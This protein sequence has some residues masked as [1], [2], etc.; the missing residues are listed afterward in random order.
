MTDWRSI[1]LIPIGVLGSALLCLWL[2]QNMGERFARDQQRLI[3]LEQRDR[4]ADNLTNQIEQY[5]MVTQWLAKRAGESNESFTGVT[6]SVT[7]LRRALKDQPAS[8]VPKGLSI[9]R[10]ADKKILSTDDSTFQSATNVTID[11]A[12][13]ALNN[14]GNTKPISRII[15]DG[16]DVWYSYPVG[17]DTSHRLLARA[18]LAL[19][20]TDAMRVRF[21]TRSEASESPEDDRIFEVSIDQSAQYAI[22]GAIDSTLPAFEFRYRTDIQAGQTDLWGL[23]TR[24]LAG[25][26]LLALLLGALAWRWQHNRQS[27]RRRRR[28]LNLQERSAALAASIDNVSES[29][30]LGFSIERQDDDLAPVARAVSALSERTVNAMRNTEQSAR[31]V[32]L[33]VSQLRKSAGKLTEL[34]TKHQS[35]LNVALDRLTQSVNALDHIEQASERTKPTLIAVSDQSFASVQA[36]KETVD[37][38]NAAREQVRQ[39]EKRV[40]GLGERV[41][42]IRQTVRTVADLSDRTGILALNASLQAA[43][44][45]PAGREFAALADEV[46]RLSDS[47]GAATEQIGQLVSAIH[48]ESAQALSAIN[49]AIEKTVMASQRASDSRASVMKTHTEL[50]KVLQDIGELTQVIDRQAGAADAL[51]KQVDRVDRYNDQ[52]RELI[53]A[54][55]VSTGSVSKQA[56]RLLVSASSTNESAS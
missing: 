28:R 55:S 19:S 35:V 3:L 4:L 21:S 34:S 47:G 18:E 22:A 33:G 11:S 40:K 45:G 43:A 12:L 30:N 15:G 39:S 56:E 2:A 7:Q 49:V 51:A 32:A 24:L 41:Q 29:G 50:D 46:K 38:L 27:E 9:F 36:A 37:S 23:I 26:G 44:A 31:E 6:A 13:S 53:N 52:L 20:A 42:E 5:R 16:V 17:S 1:S 25:S 10:V 14:S 8:L 54:H 48:S